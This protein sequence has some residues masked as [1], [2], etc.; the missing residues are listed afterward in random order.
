MPIISA[1]TE[2]ELQINLRPENC[3]ESLDIC[4][5]RTTINLDTPID[6]TF[7]RVN[8]CITY[9]YYNIFFAKN[10]IN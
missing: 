4:S 6:T 8:D 9:C 7:N 5:A 1:I 2:A 10:I 3:E